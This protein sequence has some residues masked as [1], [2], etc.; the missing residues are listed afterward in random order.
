M[1]LSNSTPP[2][3]NSRFHP[4]ISLTLERPRLENVTD[5]ELQAAASNAYSKEFSNFLNF[6]P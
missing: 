5:E 1:A 2:V 3:T 6:I 4:L